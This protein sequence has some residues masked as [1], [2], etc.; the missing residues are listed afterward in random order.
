ML[1][2]VTVALALMVN[3]VAESML[4]MRVLV[5]IPLVPVRNMPTASEAV[6]VVVTV[7]LLLVVLPV[8]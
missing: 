8:M 6:E 1:A 4:R 3:C 7:G 5:G 2:F